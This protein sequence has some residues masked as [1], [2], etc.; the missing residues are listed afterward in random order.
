L[1]AALSAAE[2]VQG[3]D[4]P[5]A[6][7]ALANLGAFYVAAGNVETAGPPLQRAEK[8]VAR[9]PEM[10]ALEVARILEAVGAFYIKVRS[11]QQ[12]E[13]A[14][15]RALEIYRREAG[16]DDSRTTRAGYELGIA[17]LIFSYA[18]D[19][20]RPLIEQAASEATLRSLAPLDVADRLNTLAELRMQQHRYQDVHDITDRIL[21]MPVSAQ[22]TPDFQEAVW[23][24]SARA[25][26]G[27]GDY[28]K[29]EVLYRKIL[30]VDRVRKS[31]DQ[32]GTMLWILG[33]LSLDQGHYKE[34]DA[35]YRE[36][37][38]QSTALNDAL[39][40]DWLASNWAGL[41]RDIGRTTDADTLDAW[42][43]GDTSS[44]PRPNIANIDVPSQVQVRGLT[45]NQFL[46]RL[47]APY[48]DD[49]T[50]L[51]REIGIP[52]GEFIQCGFF[53]GER[54]P[55]T[56]ADGTSA[57]IV[58]VQEKG[59][60]RRLMFLPTGSTS[61]GVQEWKMSGFLDLPFGDRMDSKRVER[62]GRRTWLIL[63]VAASQGGTLTETWYEITD[64]QFRKTPA[65]PIG[66]PG[67]ESFLD[68]L[69]KKLHS[70]DVNERES[71]VEKIAASP[72]AMKSSR[73]AAELVDL[74]ERD[75]AYIRS[76]Y[77][78][79]PDVGVGEGYGEYVS[80][81]LDVVVKVANLQDTH[82]LEVLAGSSYNDGSKFANDLADAG[83]ATLIPIALNLLKSEFIFDKWD[84]I[85]LLARIYEKRDTHMLAAATA[86]SLKQ[87][88]VSATG[89]PD[90]SVRMTAVRYL[91][92][93]GSTEDLPLLQRIA[94]SN[95]APL[96]DYALRAMDS[97]RKR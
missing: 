27:T 70:T 54:E 75:N 2:N 72:E 52:T 93:I 51:W 83:G 1:K 40:L 57:V 74:L 91:G 84:A 29:A 95:S 34:A 96:K 16:P 67:P 5:Q 92:Q 58:R 20:A 47:S 24:A 13:T 35:D 55:V 26:I 66:A 36:A 42:S 68:T 12:A 17:Y 14:L 90:E 61:N 65:Y 7:T 73:V 31:P 18:P 45:P 22:L 76:Q 21:A 71:A 30:D 8:I 63:D 15:S 60:S 82:T 11:P 89:D 32:V 87:T 78:A 6:A 64:G 49:L 50:S 88:I 79:S 39:V 37:M 80:K 38:Q 25:F 19:K 41:R 4:S 62:A 86:Q 44:A 81:L 94:D 48:R 43:R 46:R 9:H 69:L 53:C 33:G 85:G 56:L 3:V 59:P 97:I 23:E 77:K 10:P 28:A